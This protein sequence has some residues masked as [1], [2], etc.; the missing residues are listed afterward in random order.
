MAT[1]LSL[2]GMR[3]P[4]LIL[5]VIVTMVCFGCDKKEDIVPDPIV[6]FIEPHNNQAYNTFDTVIVNANIEHVQN[7]KRLSISI[8]SKSLKPLTQEKTIEIQLTTYTLNTFLIL[9]NKY[10]EEEHNY[11]LIKIEDQKRTFNFWQPIIIHPLTRELEKVLVVT[12]TNE[13]NTL[14][15]TDLSGVIEQKGSWASE[16]IGGY[17]DSRH[18]MFYTCG[19]LIDGIRGYNITETQPLWYIPAI[20]ISTIPYYNAFS[21]SEGKATSGNSKGVIESYNNDGIKI[22]SSQRINGGRFTS[23]IHQDRFVLGTFKPFVGDI[24]TIFVFNDPAGS[25]Y[26]SYQF[27]GDAIQMI[28]GNKDEVLIFINENG[29]IKAYSYNFIANSLVFIKDITSSEIKQIIG[30]ADNVFLST[31]DDILWY[32]P[33]IGSTV[34]YVSEAEVSA[35]AFD[36]ISNTLFFAKSSKLYLTNLPSALILD[37]IEFNAPIK[38]I[39]LL[40]NK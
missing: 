13:N 2:I 28:N 27:T 17:A 29:I 16:Y 30:D 18:R 7:I 38:D 25:V 6:E 20:P 40:Y 8:Y 5:A 24:K 36:G 35:L 19:K 4:R 23:I 9:D 33:A 22:F 39:K 1:T 11:L 3:K 31:P 32:R 14:N 10:I 26:S 37:S 15:I 34:R 21:A 12:G